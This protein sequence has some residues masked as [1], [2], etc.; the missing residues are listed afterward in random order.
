MMLS[1]EADQFIIELRMYLLSKGK[2]EEEIAEITAEL[3]DHLLVAEAEGKGIKD[4]IG[5]SPRE[6]MKSIGKEMGFDARQFMTLAPMT[7]LLVVAFSCFTPALMGE[8]SLSKVGIWGLGIVSALSFILYGFLLV[9]VLP[10]FFHSKWFFVI[11]GAAYIITTGIFLAVHFLEQDPFFIASPMQNNLIV[12]GC[13]IVFIT[14]AFYSKSW[15]TIIVPIFL[16]W[17]PLALRFT[18]EHINE[19]PVYITI[20]IVIFTLITTSIIYFVYRKNKKKK[21]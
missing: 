11:V 6:Y 19:D 20:A 3:E 16:S 12:I 5:S 17:G 4:I 13:I 1:K 2:K 14:W 8:F 7:V 15:I 21:A 9:R 18:P 10:K